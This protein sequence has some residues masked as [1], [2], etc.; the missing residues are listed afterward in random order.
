MI[1]PDNSVHREFWG[2]TSIII[3]ATFSV[4]PYG[5]FTEGLLP[6]P[7]SVAE[8]LEYLYQNP[9]VEKELSRK[10]IEKFSR[11]EFQWKNISKQWENIFDSVLGK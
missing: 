2:D 5:Y 10:S 11:P 6:T 8:G 9:E 7:E 3:P 1:L 4:Y